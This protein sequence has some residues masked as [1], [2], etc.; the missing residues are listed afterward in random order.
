MV[1]VSVIVPIYNVEQYLSKCVESILAQSYRNL[2]IIL[3]NDGS[4]DNSL[5]IAQ[6]FSDN[7]IR[8]INKENSGQSDCRY[9]GYHESKGEFLFF[10]DSDDTLSLNAIQDL[11][12]HIISYDADMCCCRFCLVDENGNKLKTSELYQQDLLENNSIILKE[13]LIS[14]QIK[15]T[16][17]TKLFKKSFL[18]KYGLE[19]ERRIKL[20]DDC[21]FSFLV[22]IYAGRVCFTQSVLY[23]VLQRSNSISRTCKPIM[24]TVY[25]DIYQ[26]LQERLKMTQKW[27]KVKH[28]FYGGYCKSILYALVLAAVRCPNYRTYNAI[29]S[30]IGYDDFYYSNDLRKSLGFMPLKIRL[31]F[32]L[33]REKRLFYYLISSF[34]SLFNH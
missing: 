33:S 10:M 15:G 34:S 20:H 17:W 5:L 9:I 14:G 13:A 28:F 1:K 29:Y 18:H 31:L 16:L 4:T 8:I 24:V 30:V 12:D 6:S 2:E 7:R 19:P 26:I 11:Y 3:I 22:S 27:E 32:W 21:M 23:N 25:Q